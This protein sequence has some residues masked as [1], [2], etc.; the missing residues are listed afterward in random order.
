LTEIYLSIGIKR[1]PQQEGQSNNAAM[2]NN[3][4]PHIDEKTWR[5]KTK[6]D[7][8]ESQLFKL[9]EEQG[10]DYVISGEKIWSKTIS[11]MKK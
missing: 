2:T 7:Q 10:E 9:K 4:T 6:L 5:R 1:T 11:S 8:C 3:T